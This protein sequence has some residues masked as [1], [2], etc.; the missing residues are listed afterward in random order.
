MTHGEREEADSNLGP[1]ARG[2]GP[3]PPDGIK[4]GPIGRLDPRLPK[5][6]AHLSPPLEGLRTSPGP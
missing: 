3:G 4:V 6:H 5:R 2:P 1:G